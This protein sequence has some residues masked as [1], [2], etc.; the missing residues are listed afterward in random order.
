MYML[1]ALLAAS[2]AAP[3]IPDELPPLRDLPPELERLAHAVGLETERAEVVRD[4]V[5]YAKAAE[6]RA[7]KAAKL[8]ARGLLEAAP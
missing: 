2:A 8:S 4:P 3:P 7:R 1:A 5:K 6:K